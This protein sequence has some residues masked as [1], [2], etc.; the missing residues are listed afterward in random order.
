MKTNWHT[1]PE[2]KCELLLAACWQ[3]KIGHGQ[4]SSTNKLA[5]TLPADLTYVSLLADVDGVSVSS[6]PGWESGGMQ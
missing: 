1:R 5:H 6:F 3:E 2:Y 4:I